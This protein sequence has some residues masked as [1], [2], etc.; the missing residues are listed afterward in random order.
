MW[1]KLE[2]P[3][4]V[5]CKIQA[6]AYYHWPLSGWAI[7][8]HR[9]REFFKSQLNFPSFRTGR[10]L[11]ELSSF[12]QKSW[13]RSW[14]P[15]PL[16]PKGKLPS[17]PRAFSPPCSHVRAVTMHSCR[18]FCEQKAAAAAGNAARSLLSCPGALA[19]GASCT[20]GEGRKEAGAE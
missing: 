20:G 8:L 4:C 12:I 19:G 14:A 1:K 15:F 10:S 18:C 2:D 11:A 7:N 5:K 9:D 6:M 3:K 17:A 13:A 16:P